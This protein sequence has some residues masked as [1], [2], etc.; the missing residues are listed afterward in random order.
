MT[1]RKARLMLAVATGIVCLLATMVLLRPD[2]SIEER[3]RPAVVPAARGLHRASREGRRSVEADRGSPRIRPTLQPRDEHDTC[4]VRE[5]LPG[6]TA[7]WLTVVR[8]W[9]QFALCLLLGPD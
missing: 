1:G 3:V 2:A 9:Y 4:H 8:R 6:A 5:D 7:P